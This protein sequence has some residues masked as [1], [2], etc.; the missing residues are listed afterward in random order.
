M[1]AY[2]DLLGKKRKALGKSQTDFAAS[3]NY[4]VQAIANIRK[5]PAE[6]KVSLAIAASRLM[7]FPKA[8]HQNSAP[9]LA[10][11]AK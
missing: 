6:M 9:S 2:A 10:S 4:S 11:D 3:I 8:R 1:N 5:G 7:K